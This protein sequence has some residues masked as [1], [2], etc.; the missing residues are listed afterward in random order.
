MIK[1][2]GVKVGVEIEVEVGVVFGWAILKRR[3]KKE[4]EKTKV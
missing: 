2:V 4:E 1:V 3:A